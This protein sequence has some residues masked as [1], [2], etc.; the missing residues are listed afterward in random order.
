M[1]PHRPA[2]PRLSWALSSLAA[3]TSLLWLSSRAAPGV[4]LEDAGELCAAASS[5]GVAHPPGYPLFVVLGGLWIRA[6][7]LFGLPPGAALVLF[8][9]SSAALTVG[10]VMRLVLLRAGPWSALV[11]ALALLQAPAFLSQAIVIEVYSLCGLGLA[12]ALTAALSNRPR[13]L[14]TGLALGAAVVAHPMALGAFPLL[15]MPLMRSREWPKTDS[16]AE[17]K[18]QGPVKVALRLCGGL[19]L[20]LSSFLLVLLFANRDPALHW[21]DIATF[22]DFKQ[23]IL[24]QQYA[25]TLSAPWMPRIAFILQYALGSMGLWLALALLVALLP[26]RWLNRGP[27]QQPKAAELWLP[28]AAAAGVLGLALLAFR[29]PLDDALAQ[30]RLIGALLAPVVLL[31]SAGGLSLARLEARLGPW[32]LLSLPLILAPFPARSG[33]YPGA[34]AAG[35]ALDQ[36]RAS[37]AETYAAAALLEAPPGAVLIANRLGATDL[38]LFPL[39]YRQIALG[40]RPDVHLIDRSL[41]E[42]PWYR[43]QL[44]RRHAELAGPLAALEN[45]LQQAGSDPAAQRRA[46][47]ALFTELLAGPAPVGFTDAPGPQALGGIELEPH[48]VLWWPAGSR[49]PWSGADPLEQALASEPASPYLEVF[50]EEAQRRSKAREKR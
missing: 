35:V 30:A 46:S 47:R 8:S 29:H 21:G 16:V 33:F 49:P 7:G 17:H 34:T 5:F 45:A 19:L 1:Q 40:E 3:A 48:G 13:P 4:T 9:A 2:S 6:L 43:R 26:I 50:R 28:W 37:V 41:L 31:A 15:L 39:L 25:A 11:T 20:G 12:L 36:S 24:R 14:S 10:L 27:Q 42:A 23:H 32:L 18:P 44:S 38:L 22:S